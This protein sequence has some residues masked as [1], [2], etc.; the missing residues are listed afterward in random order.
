IDHLP[1]G[2]TAQD[3]TGRFIL[4]NATAAANLATPADVLMGA[5]PADFLPEDEAKQRRQW[6]VDLFQSGKSTSAEEDVNDG[7]GERTWLTSHMPVQICDQTLLLSSSLDITERKQFERQLKRHAH[8]DEL[9]GLPN[10]IFVQQ[11][12]E[13]LVQRKE[14]GARF[15]LAFI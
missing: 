10:R 11:R 4:V 15:A 14:S 12:V 3:T 2:V 6:E 1:I 7:T 8:Y 5:S 9:T 13:Q